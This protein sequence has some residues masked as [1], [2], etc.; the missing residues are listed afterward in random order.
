MPV[1]E[2]KAKCWLCNEAFSPADLTPTVLPQGV[3]L[4]VRLADGQETTALASADP[5]PLCPNC[6]N[7]AQ[8]LLSYK[9][10]TPVS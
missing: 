2:V 3:V 10:K 4:T 1:S 9:T 6:L 5:V 7:L 8:P